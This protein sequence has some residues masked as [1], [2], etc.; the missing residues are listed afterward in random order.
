VLQALAE[1]LQA[2]PWVRALAGSIWVY[3]LVNT[4]HIVGIALLF[5]AIAPLDLRL[6]GCWRRL[7]LEPLRRVLLPTAMG[8]FVVA[9]GSGALLFATRATEYLAQPLFLA[10]LGLVG[11]A[12]VNAAWLRRATSWRDGGHGGHDGRDS[13]PA[14]WKAAGVLSLLLWLAAI[15]A[16]R[17]IG[18]R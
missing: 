6:L 2:A 17:F 7:P 12:L 10:K 4:V 11:A 13:T 8:G 3:P 14:R 18:Y 9:A 1:A 5:G 15:T 16:G